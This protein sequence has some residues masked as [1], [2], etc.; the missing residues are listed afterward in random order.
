M[1]Q[2]TNAR[3]SVWRMAW[4]SGAGVRVETTCVETPARVFPEQGTAALTA[5]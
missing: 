2:G 3:S 1:P 4:G 5:A